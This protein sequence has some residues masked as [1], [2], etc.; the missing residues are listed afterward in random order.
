MSSAEDRL[1][2]LQSC[3]Q[4]FTPE[5]QFIEG[6]NISLITANR[7]TTINVAV[8]TPLDMSDNDINNA[9]AIQANN[10]LL[11][12]GLL[13]YD[14][15]ENVLL[16][17]NSPI[18]LPPGTCQSDYLYYDDVTSTW[19]MGGN[20]VHIGCGAGETGQGDSAVAVGYSAGNNNQGNYAVAF[21]YAAGTTGQGLNSVAI[22]PL[23]GTTSQGGIAV[24]IGSS[25]GATGQ[26]TRAIAIGRNAGN[27]SQGIFTVAIGDSAGNTTQGTNAVAIGLNAG[28][29][30]QGRN[31]VAIGYSAGFSNQAANSIALN[32]S[33]SAL[34]TGN[35]G[36]FVNPVSTGASLV[37]PWQNLYYNTSTCEIATSTAPPN[38]DFLSSLSTANIN[39]NRGPG[40]QLY[41]MGTFTAPK[42]GVYAIMAEFVMIV[43]INN[44]PGVD[45]SCTIGASS[46]VGVSI[47]GTGAVVSVILKPW[48]MPEGGQGGVAYST[49]ST[50][51]VKLTA[52]E[53]YTVR[54]FT[55]SCTSGVTMHF[56]DISSLGNGQGIFNA[57]VVSLC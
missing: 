50:T 46:F 23:A 33:E 48:D 31:A 7:K 41:T 17:N 43:G 1:A 11:N 30:S 13:T 21:G 18:L 4:S 34:N 3:R 51:L 26:G 44:S 12:G 9:G 47:N 39:G 36:F 38:T 15:A 49:Q 25:A 45:G 28:C 24:A 29:T 55:V 16:L 53:I 57:K 6:T 37:A 19:K 40:E 22:G 2:S 10:I 32:A 14:S 20:K 35:A 54:G 5:Q 8:T 27:T 52:A 56:P 42:S